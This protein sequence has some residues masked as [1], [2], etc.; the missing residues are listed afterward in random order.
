MK[1]PPCR[2]DLFVTR[3]KIGYGWLIR[4]RHCWIEYGPFS[5]QEEAEGRIRQWNEGVLT[6]DA[7]KEVRRG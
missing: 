7:F 4:C 3:T 2:H 1:K 6:M 5:S